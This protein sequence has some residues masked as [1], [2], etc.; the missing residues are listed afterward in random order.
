MKPFVDKTRTPPVRGYWHDA[1][2][3]PGGAVKGVVVLAHGAGSNAE[4]PVLVAVADAFAEAGFAVLRCDLPF[5]QA[6]PHGPPFP[7]TAAQDREGL[8]NAVLSV[9][10]QGVVILGGHSYGGRQA[11]MLAAEKPGLVDALLLLSYPLHPPRKPEQLRTAHFPSL[12]TPVLFVHGARDPFG[13]QRGSAAGHPVDSGANGVNGDRARGPRTCRI[14][15]G[16]AGNPGVNRSVGVSRAARRLQGG[17]PGP[18][19]TSPSCF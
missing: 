11:S 12:R 14:R 17:P 9:R 16:A 13:S 2:I 8:E 7:A 5:R 15:V 19:P 10:G 3:E 1:A 4:A 6:R 18:R